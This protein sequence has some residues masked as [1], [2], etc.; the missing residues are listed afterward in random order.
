MS[1]FKPAI[2]KV[3]PYLKSF[4][5]YYVI[6]L[7][8]AKAFDKVPLVRLMTIVRSRGIHP[9]L[10]RWIEAWLTDRQQR[11]VLNGKQLT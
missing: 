9:E 11:M 10:A 6:Y 8:F 3:A 4:L 7:D 1:Q 2:I 5:C